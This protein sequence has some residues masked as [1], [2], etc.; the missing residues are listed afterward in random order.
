MNKLKTDG[1]LKMEGKEGEKK[2]KRRKRK[3]GEKDASVFGTTAN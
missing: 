3:T 2:E 1:M